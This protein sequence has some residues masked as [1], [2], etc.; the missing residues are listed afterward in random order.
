MPVTT[1]ASTDLFNGNSTTQGKIMGLMQIRHREIRHREGIHAP[2]VVSTAILLIFGLAGGAFADNR[3]GGWGPAVP[4]L[5]TDGTQVPGGCPIESPAG[6]FLFT[7]RNPTTMNIDIYVN[8]RA[9]IGEPFAPGGALPAPI[10][11]EMLAN[12]FCPTPLPDNELYFVSNRS[13]SC[14]ATDMYRAVQNPA[15]GWSE[16]VQLGCYPDGPNTPGTELSP[17]IIETAWGTFLYFSTDYHTGNQDIY[18]SRMRADGTFGPGVRLPY[19][20]NTEYDDRQPNV[21]QNGREIVFASNRP[22]AAG[23]E[24]GFDIFIAKR[25]FLFARWRRVTNLSETV[26]FDTVNAGETRPSLSWDGERMVYGSGGVWVS[27]RKSGRGKKR[28]D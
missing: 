28:D 1:G 3:S 20:I 8:E 13:G 2:F 18:R 21:S 25:R 23:D 9:A 26:P 5:R 17:S 6:R 11:D 24:T 4:Q 10:N 27:E 19:P 12:D 7:A 16:P 22:T 14:G 15:T